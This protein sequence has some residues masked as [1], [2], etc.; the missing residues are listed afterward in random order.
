MPTPYKHLAP[1]VYECQADDC[2]QEATHVWPRKATAE[3]VA[4]VPQ[5]H[6]E[7]ISEDQVS[8]MS[9]PAHAVKVHAQA[10]LHRQDCP[11]PN[12]GCECNWEE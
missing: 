9:C 3:E 2:T 11:A 12:P 4:E 1:G 8:V 10:R 6:R 5:E 7:R